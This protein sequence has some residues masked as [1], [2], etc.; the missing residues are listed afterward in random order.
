VMAVGV[1]MGAGMALAGSKAASSMLFGLKPRDPLTLAA[2]VV[3]LTAI[4]LAASVI[5]ARRASRLDPIEALRN[6]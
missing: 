1:A 3:L 6:E 5:P 2:A 4:G